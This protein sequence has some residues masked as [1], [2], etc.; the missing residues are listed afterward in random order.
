MTEQNSAIETQIRPEKLQEELGVGKDTY[1]EDLDFLGIKEKVKKQRDHEGKVFLWESQANLVRF[2]RSHV[3]ETG[4]REGFS[5]SNSE[6]VPEA[7]VASQF[8]EGGIMAASESVISQEP[9]A[10]QPKEPDFDLEQIIRE[11]A[12]LKGHQ[13]SLPE[14]VKL[15]LAESMTWDDLPEDIKAKVRAVRD[16]AAPKSQPLT[17]ANQLLEK[18]RN[19][20]QV[21]V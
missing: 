6:L 1:Y 4:K 19:R 8:S 12:E 14:L 9:E 16:A 15:K 10:P 17:I 2:L 20:K 7:S 13:M 18:W 5:V 11:A 3:S 21:A